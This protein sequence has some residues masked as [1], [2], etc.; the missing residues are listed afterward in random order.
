[1]NRTLAIAL[2]AVAT[3]TTL[4]AQHIPLVDLNAEPGRHVLVDRE[5]G[6]YLGHVTTALLG[7][8]R[9]ILATY[10]KGHGKGA[11]VLKRS[12]DAGR[13]WS[14][15]LAVPDNWSTS[16]EVPTLFRVPDTTDGKW[17]LLMF[18]GLYPARLAQSDDEG[19]SWSPLKPIGDWGGIVVMGSVMPMRDGSLLAFFHDD[20]RYYK[21]G[22]KAEG[23]FRLFQVRSRDGGRTW[24]TPDEI[25]RGSKEHLCEPGAVRSPDGRTVALLLR[26]NR[27]QAESHVMFTNDE[28]RSWSAPQP[29]ART[30]TGDRHTAKYAADGRLV[31][32][33]RDMAADSP[34]KGDWV[35]WV[36]HWNDLTAGTP[37]QYRVRL[38]DNTNAWDSTYPGLER[39]G[40]GSFVATTYG[41][42]TS[43]EQPYILSTRFTLAELDARAAFDASRLA[44]LDAYLQQSV[45]SQWIAGAVALVLRDG[46]VAYEKAV[47]WSDR[48]AKKPMT[49]DAI[50]RIASQTKAVT[51][52]AIMMLIEE[53][54]IALGDPV[55]KWLPSFARTTVA[56]RADTGRTL[57]PAQRRITIFDLLTHSAGISYGT[58]A[59]IA[60]RYRALGLG[61][62]AGWGWYTAD[63]NEDVC[64]T[65][66]RLGTLPFVEQ[67]GV[68]F[69]YGYSTDILGCVVERASGTPLDQFIKQR[70]TAPLGMV[71]TDFFVPREKVARFTTVYYNDEKGRAVRADTGARGQGHYVDGPRRNFAGG[72]GLTSTA[73]DYARFL[74]TLR[75]GGE[76]NGTRVVSPRSVELMTTNQLGTRYSSN[77]LGWGL[78]FETVDRLG[79]SGYASVGNFGWGG[80][81][82]TIYSVDPKNRLVM[83]LM[84]Q[85][86]PSSADIRAKFSTLVY[87]AL[88]ETARQ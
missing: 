32:T 85:N 41:H 10:P 11:I 47:G 21:A 79:A 68:R 73:R 45:D 49:T 82:A 8:G 38:K 83:V 55:S 39:L 35:V 52:T 78:A 30:L 20:G 65:M 74:E 70:I 13:T 72:A 24:G 44:R 7:D 56:S 60:E 27:R 19:R 40:D 6:Q 61:P 37:G 46:E 76:F 48:E 42:W 15:R 43:G 86:L 1:M 33:F 81:Y 2:S 58:E 12:D 31:I 9:T 63:K 80:A 71:D 5:P 62:A 50:F 14:E 17:R 88:I 87:Q 84:L 77:G 67:P 22:G 26:E 36:G 25:W 23:V 28:G 3:A 69:V 64:T 29:V 57:V 53:G 66:D 16:L 4:R 34:T 18:S 54:K 59:Y 75:R 51:S